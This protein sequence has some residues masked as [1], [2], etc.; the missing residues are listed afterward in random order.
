MWQLIKYA[1]YTY[2]Y[3]DKFVNTDIF[4]KIPW[5]HIFYSDKKFIFHEQKARYCQKQA[6]IWTTRHISYLTITKAAKYT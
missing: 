1:I 4:H 6:N 3:N 5:Q 2:A